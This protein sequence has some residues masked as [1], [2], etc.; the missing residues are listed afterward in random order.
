MDQIRKAIIVVREGQKKALRY[1][2]GSACS[3]CPCRG[4][5]N[6]N[7]LPANHPCIIS[8]TNAFNRIGLPLMRDPWG[9]PYLINENELEVAC[10]EDSITSAG[11]DRFFAPDHEKL[12]ITVPLYYPCR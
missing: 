7:Q 9:S 2:T 3:E 1:I 12:I 5:A 11:P 8:M 4:V 6:L 10:L